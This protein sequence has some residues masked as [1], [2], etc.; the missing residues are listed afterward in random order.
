MNIYQKLLEVRKSVPYLKKEARAKQY[1]YVGSSQT[2]GA[3]REKLDEMN[4]VLETRVLGHN[5]ISNV[6]DK[7]TMVH[8]TELD[9][10]YTWVN[11]EKPEEKVVIPWYGQGVDL[12]GEKG[13]GKALTYAEKYFILKQFNIATDKDDPDAFR[14]KADSYRKPDAITDEQAELLER[15][16]KEF[17]RLRNASLEDTFTALGVVDLSKLTKDQA[18]QKLKSLGNWI[19]KAK[20]ENEK[21]EAE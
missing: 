14:Q 13:V 8:F 10:E 19:T 2:L 11:A 1:D 15:K 16:A 21:K 6:N 20:K 3:V 17:A 12:A 5:L 18:A 9:L 7:G 4:L